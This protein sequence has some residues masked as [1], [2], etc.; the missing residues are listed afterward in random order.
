VML[1][2]PGVINPARSNASKYAKESHGMHADLKSE[3]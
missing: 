1:F 3:V 2:G